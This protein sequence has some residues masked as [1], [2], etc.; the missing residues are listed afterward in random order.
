MES[1][2]LSALQMFANPGHWGGRRGKTFL[3]SLPRDTQLFLKKGPYSTYSL[4]NEFLTRAFCVNTIQREQLQEQSAWKGRDKSSSSHRF[5]SCDISKA[6]SFLR[7]IA[8]VALQAVQYISLN[9]GLVIF[10]QPDNK[11]QCLLFLVH[12]Q[13]HKMAMFQWVFPYFSIELR[14]VL[15]FCCVC[16]CGDMA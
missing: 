1:L 7:F 13:R 5:I 3:V 8:A 16:I 11:R 4:C 12:N 2:F 15:T 6:Q 10:M 14:T 9:F